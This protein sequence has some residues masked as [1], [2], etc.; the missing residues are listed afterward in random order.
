MMA[1]RELLAIVETLKEFGNILLGSKS[2]VYT[3]CQNPTY[4]KYNIDRVM[5]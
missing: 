1:E 4:K 2:I 3:D 5:R